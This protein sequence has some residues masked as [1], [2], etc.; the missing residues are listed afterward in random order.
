MAK[1]VLVV[2]CNQDIKFDD[3]DNIVKYIKLQVGEEYH[4]IGVLK[5]IEVDCVT[6]E[7]KIFTIDGDKYSYANIK[8]AI[9]NSSVIEIISPEETQNDKNEEKNETENIEEV[10]G[11]D[12]K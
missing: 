9:E 3:W 2:K 6:E 10:E 12:K 7:N 4:V 11:D 5:G 1:N 8:E